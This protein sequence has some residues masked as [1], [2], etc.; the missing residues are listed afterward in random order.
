MQSLNTAS[1]SDQKYLRRAIELAQKSFGLASP[2]PNVGAVLANANGEVLGEGFHT[3]GGKKHAEVLAVQQAGEKARG[4]TLYINLEPCCHHGR[5]GPCTDALISAG[6]K[7]V[8][9]C[10][11]DPNPVI[12][13]RGFAKLR[14]AGVQVT[15]GVLEEEARPLND[16]FAKYIRYHLPLVTLKAAMTLDGKIAPPPHDL[17][18]GHLPAGGPTGGWITSEEARA[19]VQLLRHQHDAILVG[20]GTVIADNP[21]LTD[22][23]GLPRRRALLRVIVDSHLRLP[24]ESRIVQTAN[25]DVLVFCSFAEEKRKQQLQDRG[26]QV[27][28]VESAGSDGRPDLQAICRR[29]GERE[30]T[31]VMIEGGAMV[32]WAALASGTADKVFFYYSPK[33]L[34]GTGSVPFAAGA[35]FR[36]MSEAAHLK[37][38][39]LHRFGEDFAVEG[40]LRDPYLD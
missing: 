15:S 25:N 4:A 20:V 8:V 28:Q 27:Q 14:Q 21:L 10:M 9:A 7:R 24:L 3:Y 37:W 39:R 35:G 5:T 19:H 36:K 22:R 13:G 23:S 29:L 38:L 11:A 12:S 18:G 6:I 33:I 16:A 34:A 1:D 31:S 17:A 32:N 2:N 26:I 30:I 40:Y